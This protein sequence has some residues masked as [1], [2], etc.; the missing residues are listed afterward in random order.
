M[1][2]TQIDVIDVQRLLDS[3]LEESKGEKTLKV[4]QL[5]NMVLKILLESRT[6]ALDET[7]KKDADQILVDD[8]KE[9]KIKKLEE[10]SQ[11]QIEVR[12]YWFGKYKRMETQWRQAEMAAEGYHKALCEARHQLGQ[13]PPPPMDL[14]RSFVDRPG[15]RAGKTHYVSRAL[16]MSR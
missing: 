5:E 12:N 8:V 11:K 14:D 4:L 3:A 9:R 6:R 15:P 1:S 2:L 10:D 7:K 16:I 13:Q